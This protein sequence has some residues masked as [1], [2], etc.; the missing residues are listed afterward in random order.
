MFKF[1]TTPKK[2]SNAKQIT[3]QFDLNGN[4]TTNE[5]LNSRDCIDKDFENCG[6]WHFVKN[7]QHSEDSESLIVRC[8]RFN[9]FNFLGRTKQNLCYSIIL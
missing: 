1:V 8:G 5:W 4:I 9:T 3:S 2:P 6:P 7:S